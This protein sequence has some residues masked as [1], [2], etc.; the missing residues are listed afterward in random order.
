MKRKWILAAAMAITL[1]GCGAQNESALSMNTAVTNEV[2]NNEVTNKDA[3]DDGQ[4]QKEEPDEE[5]TPAD[6]SVEVRKDDTAEDPA[7]PT[8]EI[9]GETTGE[10]T[11]VSIDENNQ[12]FSVP[13][14]DPVYGHF[15]RHNENYVDTVS[16]SVVPMGKY[17]SYSIPEG[18]VESI[19]DG[20]LVYSK[21]SGTDGDKHS[22]FVYT[23]GVGEASPE[24]VLSEYDVTIKETF[25][26][27]CTS[28]EE[29]HNGMTFNHYLYDVND[30]GYHMY[31]NIY[32]Y[33]DEKA[34]IYV[35]FYDSVSTYDDSVLKD[36]MDSIQKA[37]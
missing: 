34:V 4:T 33:A 6:A 20:S 13:A 17:Y 16:T 9:P 32:T 19:I 7:Q 5:T 35:E 18:Y 11:T 25:G 37:E 23:E 26:K 28:G 2:T 24:D 36:F 31:T 22:L 1:T 10:T 21:D 30:S 14:E 15:I 12:D 29:E 8:Q 3:D 27:D